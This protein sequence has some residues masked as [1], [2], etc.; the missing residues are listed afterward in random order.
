[1][2][3]TYSNEENSGDLKTRALVLTFM[4]IYYLNCDFM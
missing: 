4:L 3:V 2:L 1:M